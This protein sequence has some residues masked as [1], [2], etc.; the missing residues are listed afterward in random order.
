MSQSQLINNLSENFIKLKAIDFRR[1]GQDKKFFRCDKQN[2][3]CIGFTKKAIHY[4][5]YRKT[6]SN[7]S[8]LSI[9]Q[10]IIVCGGKIAV[11]TLDPTIVYTVTS[12]TVEDIPGIGPIVVPGY[13]LQNINSIKVKYIKK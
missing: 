5:T 3:V 9:S 2:E 11:A 10:Q 7:S 12:P 13:T 8:S 1:N 6:Y 4:V